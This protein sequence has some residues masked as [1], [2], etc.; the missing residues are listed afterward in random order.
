MLL[1]FGVLVR[2]VSVNLD[3]Y[4]W[5]HIFQLE[6]VF[7]AVRALYHEFN[8]ALGLLRHHSDAE[9]AHVV[10]ATARNQNCVEVSQANRTAKFENLLLIKLLRVIINEFDFSLLYMSPDPHFISVSQFFEPYH[11]I[12]GVNARYMVVEASFS[13]GNF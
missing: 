8:V 4:F 5:L 7:E 2:S 12:L 1:S 3:F 9:P 10:A 11:W 13:V 6:V